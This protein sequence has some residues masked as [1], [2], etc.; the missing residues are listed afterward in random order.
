MISNQPNNHG[1]MSQFGLLLIIFVYQVKYLLRLKGKLQW[2]EIHTI[3]N[4]PGN[5]TISECRFFLLFLRNEPSSCWETGEMHMISN[6]R[7]Y[8]TVCEFG[9]L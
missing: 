5:G 3:F 7:E 4:K 2:S 6:K 1:I 9:L 8:G